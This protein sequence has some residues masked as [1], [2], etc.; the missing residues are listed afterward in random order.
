MEHA[1]LTKQPELKPITDAEF[2]DM[3]FL[4]ASRDTYYRASECYTRIRLWREGKYKKATRHLA[5]DA[6]IAAWNRRA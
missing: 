1:C 5:R 2:I 6:A 3:L 4:W